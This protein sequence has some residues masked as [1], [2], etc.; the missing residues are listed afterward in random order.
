MSDSEDGTPWVNDLGHKGEQQ[1]R[2][3]LGPR[4]FV[5]H[6]RKGNSASELAALEEACGLPEGTLVPRCWLKDFMM[7][8]EVRTHDWQRFAAIVEAMLKQRSYSIAAHGRNFNVVVRR[9]TSK[10]EGRGISPQGPHWSVEQ[11]ARM[12]N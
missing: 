9:W 8:V 4:G 6:V 5:V 11:R 12:F 3:E 2:R 7:V 1:M 10:S